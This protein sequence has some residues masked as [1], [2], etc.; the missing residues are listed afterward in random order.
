MDISHF[1]RNC[2]A[3]D[4]T[5]L[6]YLCYGGSISFETSCLCKIHNP[7]HHILLYIQDGACKIS[8]D[9]NI[10]H[11]SWGSVIM[12]KSQTDFIFESL[13]PHFTYSMYI[14]RGAVIDQYWNYLPV[15]QTPS[16]YI[17]IPA[18]NQTFVLDIIGKLD[19]LLSCN[20]WDGIL[21]E[22][23]LIQTLLT[24]L[25]TTIHQDEASD[26]T[27]SADALPKHVV[28]AKSII[29][30]QYYRP[31][32]LEELQS[33]VKINKHQLCRDFTRYLGQ[34]PLKYLNHYRIGKAVHLLLTTDDTIHS[35]G[36]TVGI[37][38]TTHFINLFKAQTGLT[39]QQYRNVHTHTLM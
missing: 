25:I 7:D 24:T 3:A 17:Y 9:V 21:S 13:T 22:S 26:C 5:L 37:P 14:L 27:P 19:S 33:Q 2:R 39:P 28:L 12:I 18:P 6:P 36:D 15:S 32:S 20:A 23:L 29:E 30:N 11:A 1:G 4:S 31:L 8:G 10:S 35:I 38:N 34:P 16:D